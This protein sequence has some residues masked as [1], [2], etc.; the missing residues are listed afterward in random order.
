M[1]ISDLK[2]IDDKGNPISCYEK[3]KVIN[4]NLQEIIEVYKNSLDDAILFG[5]TQESFQENI[6]NILQNFK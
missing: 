5:V 3:L 4:Q 6:I 2:W 1:E